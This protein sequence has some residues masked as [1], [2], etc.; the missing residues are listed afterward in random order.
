MGDD[1]NRAEIIGKEIL[2][3]GDSINIKT[4]RWLVKENDVRISKQCL[5]QEYL[6]L[7]TFFQGCH[8]VIENAIRKAKPLDQL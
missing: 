3:P 1:K 4:V 5:S 7:F 2:K 8:Y 6:D